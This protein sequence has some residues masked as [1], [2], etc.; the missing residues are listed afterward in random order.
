WQAALTALE[1][2]SDLARRDILRE[3][4]SQFP[5]L[6]SNDR[7]AR[8]KQLARL[9]SEA[10]ELFEELDTRYYAV[11]HPA[12]VTIARLVLATPEVFRA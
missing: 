3:A 6:P 1:S 4:I 8:H 11:K 2:A 10:T 12:E 5:D 7:D 9:T